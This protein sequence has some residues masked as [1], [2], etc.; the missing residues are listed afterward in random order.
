MKSSS[1]CIPNIENFGSNFLGLS[2]TYIERK[3]SLD[4]Q[5][6]HSFISSFEANAKVFQS[7]LLLALKMSWGLNSKLL[8]RLLV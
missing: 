2:T 6:N 1:R 4:L 3:K 5:K 7:F 8:Y